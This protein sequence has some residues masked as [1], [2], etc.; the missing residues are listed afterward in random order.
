[1]R[2]GHGNFDPDK[3]NIQDVSLTGSITTEQKTNT[4]A[5]ENVITFSANIS[6]IEIYHNEVALQSFVVNGLTLK[7][8]SG[9]WRSPIGGTPATTVTIPA[10]TTCVVTRLV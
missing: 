2:L 6:A 10:G 3:H 8:A 7:I 5:A 1:M 4:D 9:G